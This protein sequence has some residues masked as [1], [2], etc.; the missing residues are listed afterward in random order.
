M[1]ASNRRS[2]RWDTHV[3]YYIALAK[4]NDNMTCAE[5]N[6][7]RQKVYNFNV[8]KIQIELFELETLSSISIVII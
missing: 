8:T 5:P 2:D 3:V 4:S 1:V 7:S 6:I